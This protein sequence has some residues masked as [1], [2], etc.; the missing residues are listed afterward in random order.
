VIEAG[1]KGIEGLDWGDKCFN[2]DSFQGKS[3]LFAD[4]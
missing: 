4:A 1:M 2:V 3:I